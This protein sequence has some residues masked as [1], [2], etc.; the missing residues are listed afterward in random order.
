MERGG[1]IKLEM[2]LEYRGTIYRTFKYA[3]FSDMGNIWLSSAYDEMPLA[4]FS[5]DRFYKEIAV[6][7]GAGLRLDFTFFVVRLDYGFPIYDP[8][9]PVGEYWYNR[10]W[11]AQNYWNWA[12]GLQFGINYAF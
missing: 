8:S 3:I 6:C 1:D 9:K 4:E 7:V 11:R 10:S 5:F 2:N 12:Q